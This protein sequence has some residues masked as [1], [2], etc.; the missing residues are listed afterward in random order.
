MQP[1]LFAP[2]R[3]VYGQTSTVEQ[4]LLIVI[5]LVVFLGALGVLEKFFPNA[6]DKVK[7]TVAFIIAGLVEIVLLSA[8]FGRSME[9]T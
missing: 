8:G 7:Q 1:Q 4:V 5:A 9:W 6:S 3:R 2:I